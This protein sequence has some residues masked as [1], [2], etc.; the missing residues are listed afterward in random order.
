MAQIARLKADETFAKVLSK[1]A[2]FADVFI[3]NL[4]TKLLKYTRIN[5]YTIELVDD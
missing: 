4:T 2:D 3:P 1:Y 5:N